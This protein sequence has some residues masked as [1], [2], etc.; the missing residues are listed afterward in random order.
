MAIR[1]VCALCVLWLLSGCTRQCPTESKKEEI[2][3]YEMKCEYVGNFITGL[4]RCENRE[5]ICYQTYHGL[6]CFM[7]KEGN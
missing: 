4:A 1:Y 6:S 5:S 7:K 3:P 2:S